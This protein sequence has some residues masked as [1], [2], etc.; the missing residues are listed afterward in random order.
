[1]QIDGKPVRAAWDD[2]MKHVFASLDTNGDNV[3]SKE[4]AA[5]VPALD[6]ILS[7]GLGSALGL[8]GMGAGGSTAPTFEALDANKD[9]KVTLAELS[10]YYQLKGFRPVQLQGESTQGN[11]LA[12]IYGGKRPEPKVEEVAEATFALLDTN[13]DGKLTK[14]ELAAAPS[15]LLK[16]DEDDDEMITAAEVAPS[17]KPAGNM[18]AM[19]AM[20]GKG[21]NSSVKSLRNLVLVPA[22]GEVPSD[23]VRRMQAFYGAPSDDEEAEKKLSRKDLGL[24]EATFAR[25]D[26]NRDG[27]LDSAEL[28]GFVKRPPDLVLTMRLGRTE[29]AP[30]VGL[31]AAKN[32]PSPLAGKAFMKTGAAMLDLGKTRLDL[33]TSSEVP[34]DRASG[35]VRD[36]IIAQFKQADK[37]NKGYLEE[38]SIKGN[39]LFGS[40][41]KTMDRDGDGKLY[42]NEVIAYFDHMGEL[43]RRA[44]AACVTLV[45]ANHSR[46]LFDLLDVDRDGRL[47]VREMRGAVKLL[48]QFD[49]ERKGYLTRSDLPRS[50]QLTLRRGPAGGGAGGALAFFDMYNSAGGSDGLPELTAGPLW[51]RKMDRN[52]DG[53]V[54]RKEFL[55]TDEQ[56]RQIDA[57]GDGLISA[58]EADRFDALMRKQK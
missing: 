5:H 10:S 1:V 22:I 31:V 29:G 17:A 42:E 11:P 19:M 32:D 48:D 44:R 38:K 43:Q 30:R 23:L 58:A 27:V 6:Q 9:G 8:G 21:G 28:A 53:D 47:S 40:L 26:T 34:T 25:L 52:R 49:P 2:F 57:D 13:R 12:A 14:D 4:E 18:L 46:G 24:D 15:V 41:F 50:Y 45:L 51:F 54:S 37:A 56:F 39:R 33:R 35:I 36:Q 16:R 55:G 20:G 3:L 7:G